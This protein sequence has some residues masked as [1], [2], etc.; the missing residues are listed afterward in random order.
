MSGMQTF[1]PD[2][3]YCVHCHAPA[4]GPCAACGALCCGDCVELRLGL[5]RQ[6]AVCRVCITAAPA[7]RR[8][9]RVVVVAAAALALLALSFLALRCWLAA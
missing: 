8:R 6:Q 9:R 5:T 7:P 4:A 1:E 2:G 3:I